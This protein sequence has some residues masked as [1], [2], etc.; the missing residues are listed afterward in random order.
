MSFELKNIYKKY[1][2]NIVL[3]KFNFKFEEGLYLLRGI[4]G[5]GKS[6]LLKIMAGIILPTNINYSIENKK[7]AYLCEK[8]ELVNLKPYE[9]LNSISKINNIKNDIK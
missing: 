8:V 6:T 4:N 7:V 3:N 1:R 9:F 2:N 5:I